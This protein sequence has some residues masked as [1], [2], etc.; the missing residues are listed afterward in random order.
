MLGIVYFDLGRDDEAIAACKKV[1]QISPLQLP[2]YMILSLAYKRQ[3]HEEEARSAAKEILR[4]RPDFIA[5]DYTMIFRKKTVNE[6][7]AM[8]NG[9]FDDVKN[10]Q[11]EKT[12]YIH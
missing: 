10:L 5:K 3:G 8:L 7:N 12:G 11:K 2:A 6:I 1:I 9:L 4:I